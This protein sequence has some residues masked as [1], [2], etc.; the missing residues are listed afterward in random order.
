MNIAI[1]VRSLCSTTPGGVGHYVA[2]I[3]NAWP[4][5]SPDVVLFSAG[6]TPPTLPAAVRSHLHMRLHHVSEPNRII[7]SRIALGE[8]TLEKLLGHAVDTVWFPN[9]GFLPATCARRVLTVHDLAFHFMPETYTW[10]HHLRYR[11]TRA[12]S[13]IRAA[14]TLIAI[15]E[16]TARDVA[17]LS[18][19]GHIVT[20]PHGVD[21]ER[22]SP[23][24]QPDDDAWRQRLGVRTPYIVSIATY[25]PRKNLVSLVEAFDIIAAHNP[26]L[27]LVLA[28]ERGWK[29]SSLEHAIAHAQHRHRIHVLGFVPDDARPVI[30]R[31]A[32]CLC[33][34]SRYEGFGMQVLEAMACGTPV[35]CANNS[36][37]PEVVG[38][39]AIMIRASDVT[40]LTRALQELTRDDAL[41]GEL[42]GRGLTR[43]RTFSWHTAAKE[44]LQTLCG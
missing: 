23:Q 9:T 32:L 13:D 6:R 36:S 27:H 19:R 22:F 15:S 30:L 1:D 43:A 28:G 11:V 34:P 21:H 10:K 42:A 38:E 7:N 35:I 37:L 14:D 29:R 16:S 31:G 4:S 33:L 5:D 24:P 2:E 25:E 18:P 20:I 3:L 26:E 39:A 40:Q 8:L 44:T 41:R 12:V 17:S